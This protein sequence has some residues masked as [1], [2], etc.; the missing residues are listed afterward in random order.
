MCILSHNEKRLGKVTAAFSAL[1]LW[2][3]AAPAIA[4]TRS[5]TFNQPARLHMTGQGRFIY[6]VD[7]DSRTKS[8][9]MAYIRSL[10]VSEEPMQIADALYVGGWSRWAF[11]CDTRI[12][13]RLDY[14]SMRSDGHEGPSTPVNT[15]PYPIASGGD[16]DEIAA[17]ACGT[18]AVPVHATSLAQALAL[19][20]DPDFE[21]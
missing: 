15:P 13:Q 14:A 17:V 21:L 1:S 6:F 7:L 10:Q 9:S 5:D 18:G 8:G 11:D 12:A 16:A 20:A 3:L 2:V 19:A 4:E